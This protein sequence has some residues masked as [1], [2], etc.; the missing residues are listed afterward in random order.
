MP[1]SPLAAD[2]YVLAAVSPML[3][4]DLVRNR[5]L[6]RAWWIWLGLVVP[7]AV[8]TNLLWNTDWWHGTARAIM[9]V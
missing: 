5:Y 2:L 8:V 4:W 1:V 3:L 9:G 6:H 7:V